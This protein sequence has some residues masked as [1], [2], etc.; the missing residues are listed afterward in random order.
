MPKP[1]PLVILK[2]TREPRDKYRW[3]GKFYKGRATVH[4]QT[5]KQGDYTIRECADDQGNLIPGGMIVERKTV[6]DFI[7][8]IRTEETRERFE[9]EWAAI[10][11]SIYK[12]LMLEGKGVL[13]QIIFKQYRS[14][15]D[16]DSA[17][18]T[19][20]NWGRTKNYNWFQVEDS[21]TGE[22]VLFWLFSGF[23]RK[24]LAGAKARMRRKGH[25]GKR[26]SDN[27]DSKD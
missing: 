15:M 2:D 5:L 20:A 14:D 12:L 27:S 10:D 11:D 19:L 9:R 13:S 8:T 6:A 24:L 21:G 23:H 16:E 4:R 7:N 18:S 26:N 22:R 25:D 17:I 3:A 1:E